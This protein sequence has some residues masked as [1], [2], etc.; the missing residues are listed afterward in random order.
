MGGPPPADALAMVQGEGCTEKDDEDRRGRSYA[1]EAPPG[2]DHGTSRA[3][4]P[5]GGAGLRCGRGPCACEP[6]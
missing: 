5:G 4:G 6:R 1:D 3:D 2:R